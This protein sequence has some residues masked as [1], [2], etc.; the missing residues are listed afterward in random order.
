MIT[1]VWFR[2]Y[3][4]PHGVTGHDRINHASLRVAILDLAR[5]SKWKEPKFIEIADGYRHEQNRVRVEIDKHRMRDDI[6]RERNRVQQEH[7]Q[8]IRRIES[9]PLERLRVAM[10]LVAKRCPTFTDKSMSPSAWTP[11]YSGLV[12]AA[13]DELAKVDAE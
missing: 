12:M 8:R 2:S 4:K 11:V 13:D 3:D 7:R 5:S 10:D 9:W 6:D 1:E